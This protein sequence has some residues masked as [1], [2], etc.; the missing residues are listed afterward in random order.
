MP[1]LPPRL[2]S[3]DSP[4]PGAGIFSTSKRNPFASFTVVYVPY[5]SSDAWAGDIGASEV[6]SFTPPSLPLTLGETVS[7]NNPHSLD[8]LAAAP[9][10]VPIGRTP[11]CLRTP[12]ASTS[13]AHGSSRL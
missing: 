9:S 4:G 3:P 7:E 2:E 13:A 8:R 12:S 10:N 6:R 11:H 1:A 5:C